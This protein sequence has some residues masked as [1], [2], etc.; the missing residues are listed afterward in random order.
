MR[1]PSVPTLSVV[2]HLNTTYFNRVW[3]EAD[4]SGQSNFQLVKAA[5][6]IQTGA[7]PVGLSVVGLPTTD[8]VY[9][10]YKTGYRGLNRF[11]KLPDD[12]WVDDTYLFDNYA[13]SVTAYTSGGRVCPTG[14][15][16][17]R[18]IP[19]RDEVLVAI[20]KMYTNK[21]TDVSFPELYMSVYKDTTRASPIVTQTIIVNTFP[22][23]TTTIATV[24]A[25]ITTARVQ[26][27]HGT[28]VAIN[29]W[30][31]DPLHLPT[32]VHDDVV[33]ITSDP[34]IVGYCDVTV[35]D[36]VTG[37]HS[38]MYN[39][40]REIIHLPK[41]LNPNNILLTSTNLSVLVVDTT[42]LKG[43]FGHRIDSHALESITHND[44]SIGRVAVESFTTALG[45]TNVKLRIYV[46]Y[47]TEPNYLRDDVNHLSDLYSLSD[48]AILNQL[49]GVST[50]QINEWRAANL[51]SSTLLDLLY[52]FVG[53]DETDSISRYVQAMGYYDVAAVLG[54]QMRFYTYQGSEVQ[55]SKP[56][57]LYGYTC[58]AL[59]YVNG[60]KI[61]EDQIGLSNY[62][63]KTFLL[64]FKI[65]SGV[66]IGDRISVYICEE[67]SRTPVLY[68]PTSGNPACILESEDYA[69]YQIMNYSPSLPVWKHTTSLGYKSF[70]ISS[71]DYTVLLKSDGTFEYKVR[72]QHYGKHFYLVPKIGLIVQTYDITTQV[73]NKQPIILDLKTQNALGADIPLFG[74]NTIEVYLNGL[75]LTEG[76]DF[77]CKPFK[78]VDDAILQNL[79]VISNSDY[80]DLEG[81][82]NK[83]EVV[84]HGDKVISQ[85]SGYVIDNHLHRTTAPMIWVPSSG[86]VFVNGLLIESV[87]A[88]GNV[89]TSVTSVPDGANFLIQYM[90]S[91]GAEK[92][93][94]PISPN[95]DINLRS[96]IDHVLG[97][98][99][100]SYPETVVI[101]R[102][103][104]LY[105]P[106]LAQI[107]SDVGNGIIS[108][109]DEPSSDR[110]LR[111]FKAYAPL[112]DRDPT[113]G[114]PSL[115]DR[116]FVSL[117]A[118]YANYS[119]TDSQQMIRVQ[120]LISLVLTP[121]ELSIKEVLL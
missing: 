101:D 118:H 110:F 5:Q 27:P 55:I 26:Y 48:Q 78:S 33:V 44:F 89:L 99:D 73:H 90:L 39:G 6:R 35:D 116:R 67:G 16:Y 63:S 57:R 106:F 1:L 20:N 3:S 42:T 4:E 109:V 38:D 53:F 74:Y 14:N 64:G 37:Y 98:V 46:R 102:L 96:R 91:Y 62:S 45:A 114:S 30:I 79:L 76:L 82:E 54:Q 97:I 60:R 105:S 49:T 25:L 113:I 22:N 108:I 13:V 41:S 86:R 120:R 18:Y 50:T 66:S 88:N 119:I 28:T 15:I 52:R 2:D 9:A 47:P 51:E 8:A 112:L 100:P 121:G 40:Y 68:N 21:C 93:I 95:A 77:E 61:A 104:A 69:L 87:Q 59:V 58:K 34:D 84:I 10:V 94:S 103:L 32:L 36:N 81:G 65:G 23:S 43:V 19:L 72:S 80:L 12:V 111:Q 85:D 56:A 71:A 7:V 92:L 117:A 17:F 107:V 11:A 29:G 24:Q 31:Y 70:P 83:V 75:R 115:V